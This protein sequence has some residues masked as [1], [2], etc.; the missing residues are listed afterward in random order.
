MKLY[1]LKPV[2]DLPK[3]DN[4]WKPWYNKCFG[5]VVRAEDEH[6]AR[7][8]AHENAGD[9]NRG[10]FAG[11]PISKTKTP[12]LD[13]KYSTCGELTVDGEHGLILQHVESA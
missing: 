3:G 10:E 1:I 2:L 8:H 6:W 13:P 4:P 12:W 7:K 11:N 9:E 5:M